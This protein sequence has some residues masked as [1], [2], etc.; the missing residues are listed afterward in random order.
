MGWVDLFC[1]ILPLPLVGCWMRKSTTGIASPSQ[2]PIDCQFH[3][4]TL[5]VID[6]SN[7]RKQKLFPYLWLID[8]KPRF[9]GCCLQVYITTRRTINSKTFAFGHHS[10]NGSHRETLKNEQ[11]CHYWLTA[12]SG[13]STNRSDPRITWILKFTFEATSISFFVTWLTDS[14]FT[15]CGLT[16]NW[17]IV[18]SNVSEFPYAVSSVEPRSMDTF[19]EK[20]VWVIEL[21]FS[22][23]VPPNHNSDWRVLE[24]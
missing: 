14:L 8:E 1:L 2:R 11:I 10:D 15:T 9:L 12:F 19:C 24:I 3:S 6:S 22:G 20:N 17:N 23:R 16:C 5:T 13:I 21:T 7:Q 18:L 4:I